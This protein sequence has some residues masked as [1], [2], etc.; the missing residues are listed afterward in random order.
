M[1]W[2][3]WLMAIPIAVALLAA[4]VMVRPAPATLLV[5][6]PFAGF[7]GALLGGCALA[8][9]FAAIAVAREINPRRWMWRQLFAICVGAAVFLLSLPV[10]VSLLGSGAAAT[11]YW[12]EAAV[13]GLAYLCAL[14][15]CPPLNRVL[16]ANPEPNEQGR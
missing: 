14:V 2:R 8:G 7:V 10:T 3:G 9:A 1:T 6:L 12:Y 13:A 15:V 16:E 4:A 11:L 5:A